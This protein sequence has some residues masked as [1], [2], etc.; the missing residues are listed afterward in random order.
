V[1]GQGNRPPPQAGRA[2]ARDANAAQARE[3]QDVMGRKSTDAGADTLRR[4]GGVPAVRA[5]ARVG[6]AARGTDRDATYGSSSASSEPVDDG[7]PADLVQ[8][9]GGST[10]VFYNAAN[11]DLPAD[12][13]FRIDDA[14]QVI[15]QQAG[16]LSFWLTPQWEAGD[17]SSGTLVQLGAGD[18]HENAFAITKDAQSLRFTFLDDSGASIDINAMTD[19]WQRDQRHLVTATWGLDADGKG[20]V[21]FYV[22]GTLVGQQP[23]SGRFE[24]GQGVPLHIGADVESGRSLPGVISN[25]QLYNRGLTSGELGQAVASSGPTK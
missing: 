4:D 24:V 2:A 25:F 9:A 16:G 13:E 14:A 11:R 17:T 20:Q 21:S 23:Y 6:A 18:V 10:V 19:G 7:P 15:G 12:K 5:L 3:G 22:D 1:E 8:P